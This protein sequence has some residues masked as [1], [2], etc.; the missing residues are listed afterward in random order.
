VPENCEY[1]ISIRDHLARGRE[2]F[3]YRVEL[4]PV[5]AS[6]T[7]GI[8]RVER[9]SQYRQTIYV[10]RGNKF[11]AIISA[12]RANFGGE[13]VLQPD[14][15][16][17]GM[18]MICEPMAANLNTMP[19]VFEAAADAPLSGKLLDFRAKLA[20][21]NQNISGGFTNRADFVIAEPGQSLYSW[22]DVDKLAFAIVDELPFKLEI[23]EPKVPLVRSG[24]MQLKIVAQRKEGFTKAINV[25]LPF[26]PP[27][28]GSASSVNIPEGQN[29]VL[30]PLN[31]NGGAE[32]KAWKIFALGQ[33]DVGGAGWV[34]SQLA[35]LNVAEPYVAFAMERAACEQGQPAQ[36]YCKITH[37]HAYEGAAKVQVVGLPNQVTAPEME[38]PAGKE[39]LIFPVTTTA[40]SPAGTHK[41]IFCQVVITENGEPVVHQVGSTELQI[42]KPLPMPENKPAPAAG[43]ASPAHAAAARRSTSQAV[44]ALGE[45]AAR[46]QAACRGRRFRVGRIP[47]D[48]KPARSG[49]R[50]EGCKVV[51]VCE[52][53]IVTL[54]TATQP[55][56]GYKDQ[57]P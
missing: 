22:R 38:L 47:A 14:G 15:L 12:S 25:Q 31:A 46:S 6:L 7:L 5:A 43:R 33:A 11:G 17:V 44:V 4:T 52:Q 39:E 34:S 36:I 30:Y 28:V 57:E 45:A 10:P 50:H 49:V 27:G 8:P 2:D 26:L 53:L 37:S 35:T 29:E 24:V 9:Y 41:N 16:P 1:L 42:D 32:I 3:T 55:R 19:V 56:M 40:E 21:P 20:D 18:T 13:L 51:P 54:A 48:H 23:V